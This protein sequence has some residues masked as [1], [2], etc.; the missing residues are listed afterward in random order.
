MRANAICSIEIFEAM[1]P[2]A[3]ADAVFSAQSIV[4]ALMSWQSAAGKIERTLQAMGPGT[5]IKVHPNKMAAGPCAACLKLSSE[6]QPLS[7]APMGPLP[8]CPHPDQ[9]VLH[10]RA[11][12]EFEDFTPG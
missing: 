12:S 10:W 6:A 5:R 4:T 3:R 7:A 9:C 8:A 11:L 2:E 1:T